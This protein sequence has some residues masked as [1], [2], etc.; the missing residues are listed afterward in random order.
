[1]PYTAADL[2]TI[3][4]NTQIGVAPTAAITQLLQAYAAQNANGSA[5]D[6][7]TL[8]AVLA[9][10]NPTTAVAI[11]TYQ[12]FTGSVPTAAGLAF[13][14]NSPANA[15]D[16]N[17]AYY[18]QFNQSNRFINFAANLGTGVGAGASSFQA[19]YGALSFSDAVNVAYETIIGSGP[20]TNAGFDPAAGKAYVVSQLSYFQAFARQN[21]PTAT[22]AQLDLIVKAEAVGFILNEAIKSSLGNYATATRALLADLGPDNAAILGSS[23]LTNYGSTSG[24]AVDLTA[25]TDLLTANVFNAGLVFTP[26]GDVRTNSLQ[27]EDQLT[28]VGTNPT[29]NFTFGNPSLNGA[30]VITPVLNNIQTVNIAFTGSGANAGGPALVNPTLD[31][32]DATGINSLN[33]SR[34]S[35][36]NANAIVRNL[37]AEPAAISVNN[38]NSPLANVQ[39]LTTGNALAGAAN[40]TT[41]TLNNAT[42]NLF[43]NQAGPNQIGGNQNTTQFGLETLNVVSNNGPNLVGQIQTPGLQ[44]LNITGAANLSIGTNNQGVTAPTGAGTQV[45]AVNNQQGLLGVAGTLTTINAANYTGNLSL[46]LANEGTSGQIANSGQPVNL[47]FTG[48]TGNDTLR[49]TATPGDSAA[50]VFDGGTGT[51]TLALYPLAGA[52]TLG[53]AAATGTFRNFQILDVR[54]GGDGDAAADVI[55]INGAGLPSIT[56]I[57]VRNEGQITIP[58]V[59]VGGV[60]T[61]PAFQQ[62]AAEVA[63]F[64]LN[65]LSVVQ[66][67]NISVRHGTTGNSGIG[68]TILNANLSANTAADVIGVALVSDVNTGIRNNLVINAGAGANTI[69]NVTIYDQDNESNT[70]AL[71]NMAQHTGLLY[72]TGGV[73]GQFMNFDST[74]PTITAGATL[75]NQNST[76][77]DFYRLNENEIATGT[78]AGVNVSAATSAN[79]SVVDPGNNNNGNFLYAGGVA[80]SVARQDIYSFAGTSFDSTTSLDNVVLRVRDSGAPNGAQT[81]RFGAG[82]DTVIFDTINNNRAGL[83]ISDTV[84]GGAGT[85]TLVFD[86]EGLPISI[87]ASEWTN[88]SQFVNIRTVG[89]G[90]AFGTVVGTGAGAQTITNFSA[91]SSLVGGNAALGEGIQGTNYTNA[92]NLTLTNDM[93]TRNGIAAGN[94]G[95]LINVINDNDIANN[96]LGANDTANTAIERG[97]TIDARGLDA[98]HFFTY[99]GEEGASR[100]ADRFIMSD[101][102]INGGSTIDGGAFY[103]GAPGAYVASNLAS[104]DILE[105]RD[106]AVVTAGDLAN[107]ANVGILQFTNDTATNQTS[108]LELTAAVID[109]LVNNTRAAN[110]TN[111][112]TLTVGSYN[113]PTL[114]AATTTVQMD[115]RGIDATADRVQLAGNGTFVIT[116]S[117]A[118][119]QAAVLLGTVPAANVTFIQQAAPVAGA[120][121]ASIIDHAGT[122]VSHVSTLGYVEGHAELF[123]G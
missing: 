113:N 81:L 16:L 79:S 88:V 45:E 108:V 92:Y 63:T 43:V 2:N 58:A 96:G 26:G 72:V 57:T 97:V 74:F 60:V 33:L 31:V 65:N 87:G 46:N 99:N 51:N 86:G 116:Y 91:T 50:D 67:Q 121:E 107:I 14:V 76:S 8:A 68:Q 101:A 71:G 80:V 64:N 118:A 100:T 61:V 20:A 10:A 40:S 55:T 83:S 85:N 48:G 54:A 4:T 42:F 112:E 36:T 115:I 3:Y 119:Q 17:D 6:A 15:T 103:G 11:T 94:G 105:V 102:N 123:I 52:L 38:T 22:A 23:L 73:A 35:D 29:L 49:L 122:D 78:N 66:G 5:T 7:Q 1:M 111:L 89:N 44:T 98:T 69:E 59:V 90:L 120:T 110:A 18:A 104:G 82:D 21:N 37:V 114:A 56:S 12:F 53:T 9:L 34:I 39:I 19:G 62:S 32:Q 28:G 41:L 93:I 13:L 25:G 117:T 95:F 47:T 70:V 84:A 27:D 109:N 24:G 106:A 77:V 75:G 30:Q